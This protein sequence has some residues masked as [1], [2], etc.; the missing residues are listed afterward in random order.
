MSVY[1]YHKHC[2]I[3]EIF[4]WTRH[5]CGD[6]VVGSCFN[7]FKH[8]FPWFCFKKI[9]LFMTDKSTDILIYKT[10][11]LLT[12]TSG[13]LSQCKSISQII[14]LTDKSSFTST[15]VRNN[16]DN[17][18]FTFWL[19]EHQLAECNRQKQVF[20]VYKHIINLLF[21]IYV[22]FIKTKQIF[23]LKYMYSLLKLSRYHQKFSNKVKT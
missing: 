7:I 12:V 8:V 16:H 6:F 13:Y 4:G 20:I 21:K 17:Y 2:K 10:P 1:Y 5:D 11:W 19:S 18:K 23:F 3:R 9:L 22:F 14:D 15:N